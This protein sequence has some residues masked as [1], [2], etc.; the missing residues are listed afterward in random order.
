MIEEF[1]GYLSRPNH[2]LGNPMTFLCGSANVEWNASSIEKFKDMTDWTSLSRNSNL[3]WSAELIKEF[4]H[5]WDWEMLCVHGEFWTTELII[6]LQNELDH[7]L[8]R[9]DYL[10]SNTHIEW[11]IEFILLFREKWFS[12]N[13]FRRHGK[14]D[15]YNNPKIPWDENLLET[16]ESSL[17]WYRLSE[18]EYLPWSKE[19]ITKYFSKWDWKELVLNPFINWD[20]NLI[21]EFEDRI[22]SDYECKRWIVTN[23]SLKWNENLI[24]R[25]IDLIDWDYLCQSEKMKWTLKLLE[26]YSNKIHWGE[27]FENQSILW[28]DE[29]LNDPL[30]ENNLSIEFQSDSSSLNNYHEQLKWFENS[31][32][33]DIEWNYDLIYKHQEHI[34]WNA[35]SNNSS[36]PWDLDLIKEFYPR[37]IG[38]EPWN[39]YDRFWGSGL[40]TDVNY[41]NFL[42]EKFP[43]IILR[44]PTYDKWV[45]Y[46]QPFL[47]KISSSEILNTIIGSGE[48]PEFSSEDIQADILEEMKAEE[49]EEWYRQNHMSKHEL[50]DFLGYCDDDIDDIS[51]DDIWDMTG[52]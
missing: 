50:A 26:K 3:P 31:K 46:F 11:T 15:C 5:N 18:S 37:M 28:N 47:N 25:F 42:I 39:R 33:T 21:T 14:N 34:N 44:I 52:H 22:L 12:T 17:N 10:L 19:L 43:D 29:M 20:E 27:L 2:I 8:E 32:K 35:L 49:D 36:V 41:Y 23:P 9:W 13:S 6:T 38:K 24:D 40:K 45:E 16:F 30:V 51:E 1:R 48:V 7:N 4:R